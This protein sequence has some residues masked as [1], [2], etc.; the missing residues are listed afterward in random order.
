MRL[1]ELKW[2]EV[3]ALARDGLVV[4]PFGSLEQH[5]YHLPLLT[6]TLIATALAERLARERP[7]RVLLAPT[8]WVGASEDHLAFPGSLDTGLKL[9]IDAVVECAGALARHD[10]R[11]FMLLNAHGGNSETLQAADRILKE[12]FPSATFVCANYWQVA[13]AEINAILE[14]QRGL[15]HACELETSILLATHPKLVCLDRAQPDGIRLPASLRGARVA[16]TFAERTRRGGF[17]DPTAASAEKGERLIGA[18]TRRLLEVVDELVR[19]ET[20]ASR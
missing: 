10:W 9:H 3:D 19:P 2:I 12:Q 16:R 13:E 1:G 20:S 14:T 11:K 18:I 17:G 5:G 6:D 4:I 8:L 15:G 7:D